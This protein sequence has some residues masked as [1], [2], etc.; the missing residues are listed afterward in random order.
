[1]LDSEG[2]VCQN[3][4]AHVLTAW[5][6]ALAERVDTRGLKQHVAKVAYKPLHRARASTHV[7]GIEV[8]V[9]HMHL[10]GRQD[11][12]APNVPACES[13]KLRRRLE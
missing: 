4:L 13:A 6:E 5:S 3:C 7:P 2:S 10:S 11:A 12:G 1:M 8:V 9:A